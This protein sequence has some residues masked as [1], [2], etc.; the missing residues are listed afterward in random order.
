MPENHQNNVMSESEE[1]PV[2]GSS[3]DEYNPESESC[4][5]ELIVQQKRVS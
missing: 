1:E 3:S 2:G 4:S 5:D